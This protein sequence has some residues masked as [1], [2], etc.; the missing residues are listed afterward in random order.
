VQVLFTSVAPPRHV[1][2]LP[3]WFP[4]ASTDTHV[5]LPSSACA[6]K[7]PHCVTHWP[8]G[9][10]VVPAGQTQAPLMDTMPP[11]QLSTAATHDLPSGESCWPVPQLGTH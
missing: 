7:G 2:L 1:M 9:P 6:M 4:F 11:V 8:R 3:T 5:P 10:V